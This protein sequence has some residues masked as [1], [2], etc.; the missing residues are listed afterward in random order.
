MLKRTIIIALFLS[1]LSA[2]QSSPAAAAPE[3]NIT[4]VVTD[5]KTGEVLPGATIVL[6]GTSL[7]ASTDVDG[8]FIIRNVPPGSYTLRITYIGYEAASLNAQ[9]AGGK[10]LNLF[11]KL[12]SVAIQ[13]EVVVVTA[14]AAGQNEAINQQLSS[15]QIVSVVSAARIQELP[16]A[17]AAE[18]IGRLPGIAVLRSGGEGNEVVV[19]GLQPKYNAITIDGV[20][21]ASSNP[22]D[23][24]TDLSMISPYMLEGIEVTKANTAD[25][26]ADVLG[27]TVNFKLKQATKEEGVGVNLIAEGGYNGLSDAVNPYNN[28]KYI[29]SVESRF[30]E[31]HSFGIFAQA[32]LERRNLSSNQYGASYT[33]LGS[34]TTDYITQSLNLDDVPRDRQRANA[35]VVM[36]YRTPAGKISLSNFF[37]SGTTTVDD[38]G[39]VYDIQNNLHDYSLAYSKSTVNI[40]TNTIDADQQVSIF[41]V[42]AKLS[43]TY[44]ETNDPG[45]WTVGFKQ[46]SAGLAPFLNVANLIPQQIPKAASDDLSSTYLNSLVSSNSFSK[47][48]ALTASLDMDT[49]INIADKLSAT[50]KFGGKFRYQ[51]RAYD[52]DQYSGQGLGLTSAG[53]VDK[54][55][56]AHFPSTAQYA[57]TTSIPMGPFVDPNFKY[58]TFLS[59]NY[60]MIFPLN[61]SMLSEVA[62]YVK[63]NASLIQQN[64]DA[65]SYFYDNFNSA[66]NDYAGHENQSAVYA[67][68]TINVGSDVTVIPGVRFQNLQTTYSGARGIQSTASATGGGAYQ[69][70][71]T[72]LTVNHGYWLPDVMLRYKP[73]PWFDARFSYTNTLAYPDYNAIIPRIDIAT[74]GAI[75]WNNYQLSP[76]RSTNYDGYLSFYDNSIGL[77]TVGGFIK[78]ID[79][80]IYAWNFYAS[81]ASALQYYPPFLST[82]APNGEYD[83]A[84]YVNDPYRINNYGLELDWQTHFWYLPHPFDGL[85]MNVNFTH[86][87]S[88][89]KYPYTLVEKVG[90]LVQ[91]VDTAFTDRL[92]FQPDNIVNLSLGYDYEGFSI[93]VSMLYQANIWTNPSIWPQL[94][95]STSAYTRWDLSVKQALPWYGLQVYGD[96]NNFNSA[97]DI[98]VIQA[99]TGVPSS[100]QSYGLTAD[101]GLRWQF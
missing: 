101:L 77:F 27:G 3:S 37:S 14:Q 69:H 30:F 98:S 65:I 44:S 60:P 39:E 47:E 57:N 43:H 23:R 78:Q 25:Q 46:A 66:T 48:R 13:G 9:V 90:R 74:G 86:I 51:T 88:K 56:A 21:M 92:L 85:V 84:T 94:K 99:E 71:D 80:L 26:D 79:N 34:S 100:E 73:L 12:N 42:D 64:N 8:K 93:R 40:I 96:L 38:R 83:I 76:S 82:S 1:L 75:S 95:G 18:A 31:D 5:S 7:G 36:D 28:Y 33:H 62:S 35:T 89:A 2:L 55:I 20:R 54:L 58:G 29:A 67:M 16:D 10:D 52:Y 11:F 32:D 19:R 24:S 72:T 45:D 68:T 17:N 4:G 53:Y 61:Y 6:A 50:I 49:P 15:Q 91:Y 81:G 63:S 22:S 97:N 70:Y 87:Y 41:H 59:G